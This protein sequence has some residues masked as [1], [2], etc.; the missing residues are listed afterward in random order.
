MNLPE[1]ISHISSLKSLDLSDCKW[2]ECIPS[3]RLKLL[4]DSKEGQCSSAFLEV[5]FQVGYLTVAR[6]I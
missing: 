5:Q 4:S 2:F 3:S 1:S 6:D